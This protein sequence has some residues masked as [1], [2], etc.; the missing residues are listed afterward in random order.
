MFNHSQSMLFLKMFWIKN[1][2]IYLRNTKR[3]KSSTIW[4]ITSQCIA[5]VFLKIIWFQMMSMS[6]SRGLTQRKNKKLEWTDYVIFTIN[7]RRF[8]QII[9][10]LFPSLQITYSKIFSENKD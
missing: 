3:S 4:F 2:K 10:V 8:I 5:L 9:S 6:F 7:I 1:I